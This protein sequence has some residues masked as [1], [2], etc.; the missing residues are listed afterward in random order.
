MKRN[1]QDSQL[2][3]QSGHKIKP[4]MHQILARK[5]ACV[6]EPHFVKILSMAIN[7]KLHLQNFQGC[8]SSKTL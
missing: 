3:W 4:D 7:D 1:L 5:G 8:A 6:H 2:I